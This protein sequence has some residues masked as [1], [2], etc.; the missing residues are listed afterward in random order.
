MDDVRAVMDDVGSQR[1]VVIGFSE[2]AAMSVLFRCEISR[3]RNS[4]RPCSEA[5]A[6]AFSFRGKDLEERIAQVV[7]GLG[8]GRA[9]EIRG[10]Q[11]GD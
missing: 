5:F 1:A 10:P 7:E 9:N 6:A 8:H 4:T 11:P 3:P 2:G